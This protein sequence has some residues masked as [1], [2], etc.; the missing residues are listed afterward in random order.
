MVTDSFETFFRASAGIGGALIGLLFVAIS[1][2]PQRT[3][4]P[5]V[6]AGVQDQR[7]AGAI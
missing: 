1:I 6:G 7:L 3:F 4:D 2:H 5:L